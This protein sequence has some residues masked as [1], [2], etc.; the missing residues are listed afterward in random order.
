MQQNGNKL[1]GRAT[2]QTTMTNNNNATTGEENEIRPTTDSQS[3]PNQTD[4][5]L[6]MVCLIGNRAKNNS[7]TT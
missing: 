6:I 7:K 1:K 4:D 2:K 3:A 5:A